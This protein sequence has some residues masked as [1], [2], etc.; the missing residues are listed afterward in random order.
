MANKKSQRLSFRQVII[1]GA[2][3][4][5]LDMGC[6]LKRK[7]D[8]HDFVIFDRNPALGGTWYDNNYPG[9]AVDIPGFIY[10]LSFA[11][12]K[13]FSRIF[14]DR[15]EMLS[16]MKR[17][18]EEYNIN[19]HLQP[20]MEWVSS[21]WLDG[22]K[23][24]SIE[25]RSTKTG[26][27]SIQE[28]RVLIGAIGHQVDPK[29]FNVPGKSCF[30]GEIF[31]A[32]K[33]PEGLDLKDKNVIVLGNGSTAVQVVPNIL[34]DVRKCTQIQRAPQWILNRPN[35]YVPE[36][37]R[38]FL[39]LVPFI[40]TCLQSITFAIVEAF[41]PILGRGIPRMAKNNLKECKVPEQY[42]SL[43]T[44]SHTP[45]LELVQD[46]IVAQSEKSCHGFQADTFYYP[47]KGRNGITPPEHWDIAGGPSCYKGCAMNGFPNFFSIRG[48]NVS[49]GHQSLIHFIESTTALIL[50]VATP[51]I[52]G[53]ADVVE[54][55]SKAEQSYVRRVQAACKRGFWGRDCHTFYVTEN[56]WNHTIYP[57]SPYWLCLHRFPVKSHW[58]VE[59]SQTKILKTMFKAEAPGLC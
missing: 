40:F 1:I 22:R 55:E 52:Q 12:E 49:S 37:F 7:L 46:E 23:C 5:G 16:Y 59:A 8:F 50:N 36:G 57:W 17:V 20:N 32:C 11:P 6:E 24:W 51:L 41:Y 27:V 25:L 26:E 31:H 44:P 10:Q 33:W 34:D 47:L 38:R 30:Q 13:S 29:P 4:A 53:K 9:C 2:G 58:I 54:V 18:A 35:P 3:L 21:T 19:Q 56:G 45:G 39:A 28:S 43:L 15:N 14:P 48:P 42:H